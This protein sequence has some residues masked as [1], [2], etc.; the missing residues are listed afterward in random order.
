ME[1]LKNSVANRTFTPDENA[2]G[3]LPDGADPLRYQ[4]DRPFD[5]DEVPGT[6]AEMIP[7]GYRVLDIGC[8]EGTLTKAL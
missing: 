5:P 6:A 8:G 4:I 7:I 1:T 2:A 3:L